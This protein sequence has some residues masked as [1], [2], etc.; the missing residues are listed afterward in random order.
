MQKAMV[1]TAIALI[2]GL[3]LAYMIAV[4]VSR[5]L[6]RLAGY[7]KNLPSQEF[8]SAPDPAVEGLSRRDD[9]IGRLA[10]AFLFMQKMLQ[11]YLDHLKKTTAAKERIESELKIAH[12]IQMSLV[13]KIFPPFPD[14]KEFDLYAI[15]VPAREV[16]GDFYD[17]FF[18]DKDRLCLAIG[19]VSGKGV[20][21]SLF[22]AVTKTLFKAT[23]AGNDH[24]DEILGRLNDELCKDNTTCM[25]VTFFGAILDIQTGQLEYSNA[26]HN[27][28]Y[29]LSNKQAKQL[30]TTKG[31]VVG[32]FEGAPF[33]KNTIALE[34][35]DW[36]IFYTD[37]VTEAMNA[38]KELF[39]ECRL[40]QFLASLDNDISAEELTRRLASEVREFSAGTEQSDDM[41][42]LVL[43]YWGNGNHAQSKVTLDLR[44]DLSDLTKLNHVLT[45]F[46]QRQ[47]LPEAVLFDMKLALEE[48]ITNAVCHNFTDDLEH[49]ISV[50]IDLQQH[51]LGAEVED[52]GPAFNPLEKPPPDTTLPLEERPV[53]GLGIHLV[54]TLMDEVEYRR[55]NGRNVLVLKK[56]IVER[57]R[58]AA[59]KETQGLNRKHRDSS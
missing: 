58:S 19:D 34:P 14:R 16:G 52:D 53:G 57:S 24:P 43:R 31:T 6:S 4:K 20:P 38:H 55:Q 10:Q 46:V 47:S 1:F 17:F 35:G 54:R 7:A 59:P 2:I 44:N 9:E 29:K 30:E 13:P 8:R 45:D 51:V 50:S 37:G 23:S 28:P 27:L 25:F 36:I 26:G 11:E 21:A 22:M 33:E 18:L 15:L 56:E 40:E 5:P 42:I 48:I 41:T 39:S 49:R 12:D 32:A 3:A